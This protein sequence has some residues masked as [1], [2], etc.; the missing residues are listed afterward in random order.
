[1]NIKKVKILVGL[2]GWVDSAVSAY[3]LKE[4]WY[5]VTAGF[6]INYLDEHNPQCPTREDIEIAKQVAGFLDIPFFTFDYREEY[7]EKVLNYMYEW[8]QRG[9]TPN[10]DIMCNSEI[11]FRV[12]LEEALE[13]GFDKV[14][15]GHYAQIIINT[16]PKSFPEMLS[17]SLRGRKIVTEVR[18]SELCSYSLLKWKDPLKD[19]SYFLAWLSQE[20]LSKALFPIWHL[21]KSEVRDIAREAWLPNAERKDSQ[22]ICFVGKVNMAE[23]LEKKIDH[24]VWNV[25]DTNWKIL[26]KHKGVFYYTVGQRKGLDIWGQKE[27]IFVVRKD[28]IKNEI[29]VWTTRDEKLYWKELIMNH[30]HIMSWM[31]IEDWMSSHDSSIQLHA[32]I[33]YRQK[34]Q[35]CT[36]VAL[37]SETI[38]VEFQ[39]DQRAIASGQI[40]AIYDR[41]ELIISWIIA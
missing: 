38:K 7:E 14:A 40:C 35:L 28:I 16:P 4:Q 10:P 8:Y 9:V 11:K 20:Q 15:M 3:L 30:V 23:F 29:I 37:N 39:S 2:S 6:M 13:L 36:L 34:D 17:P 5:D 41:E 18:G 32:K 22:W 33:R 19:Q 31:S 1:M 21:E 26:W 24:K 25:V 12:F 27:P